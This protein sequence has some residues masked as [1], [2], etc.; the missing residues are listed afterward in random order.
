M[1]ETGYRISDLSKIPVTGADSTQKN[2]IAIDETYMLGYA[3]TVY[4]IKYN[5][6][7]YRIPLTAIRD[8]IKGYIGIESI[9]APWSES[10]KLWHG[11][12]N[13]TASK[14]KSYVYEW[15]ESEKNHPHYMPEKFADLENSYYI[16]KDAPF[17][18]ESEECHNRNHGE[19]TPETN[20]EGDE[21]ISVNKPLAAADPYTDS[22]K[23][24][25]KSYVDERLASKRLV[26]VMPEFR[27]RDYDCTYI[28]RA[29]TLKAAEAENEGPLTIKIHYP[30]QFEKRVKNNNLHFTL[31][32][33]G[34]KIDNTWKPALK[35]NVSW[36]LI[37]S[38]GKELDICWLNKNDEDVVVI[39]DVIE[40]R[41]YDNSRY[42]IFTFRTVTNSIINKDK[43]EIV[44]G[45][46]EK[47]GEYTVADYSVYAMCE[48]MLYRNRAITTINNKIVQHL[49]LVSKDD[50]IKIETSEENGTV[51]VDFVT[52]VKLNY[53]DITSPDNSVDITSETN[54]NVTTFKL[55][56][57][58]KDT[59]EIVSSETVRVNEKKY[60]D[61]TYYSLDTVGTTLSNIDGHIK[62]NKKD[63]DGNVWYI[64]SNVRYEAGENI[65]I[66]ENDEIIDEESGDFTKVITIAAP[67]DIQ[68]GEN[69]T[70]TKEGNTYIIN[71][72]EGS[73][74]YIEPKNT[75]IQ[76]GDTI[77]VADSKH[78]NYFILNA[79]Q[80]IINNN[81]L[82]ANEVVSFGLYVNTKNNTDDYELGDSNINWPMSAGNNPPKL[83][84]G[85]L[86]YITITSTPDDMLGIAN[87][88][89]L[90]ARVNWYHM[91]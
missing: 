88:R 87:S 81:N 39:P 3:N 64:D 78:K 34:E 76:A 49:N 79:S 12:W 52:N 14:N 24:V 84:P 47:T 58:Q 63:E 86:Y 31:L 55:K 20:I 75:L 8:D 22:N 54:D 29:E 26:E 1:L 48:N 27:V 18:F 42:I 67:F 13:N 30:A 85:R 51:N 25:L 83:K 68:A 43:I 23:L 60:G 70:I 72:Q 53:Y 69:I 66:S 4:G 10:I 91:I 57:I 65:E 11:V 37:D 90:Y 19:V 44:D 9:V 36:Q 35:N 74:E 15:G 32:V 50:S 2:K 6:N 38:T 82:E 41:F 80:P 89:S 56:A 40:Q 7:N 28:L 33:E 16:V 46:E 61:I 17:P 71:G 73:N 62:V 5:R 77:N 59:I 21:I 45:K